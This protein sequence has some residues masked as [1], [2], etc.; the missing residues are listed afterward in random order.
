MA[1]LGAGQVHPQHE[2][3]VRKA[4]G[5]RTADRHNDGIAIIRRGNPQQGN[6]R[7]TNY[8]AKGDGRHPGNHPEVGALAKGAQISP[9]D[10]GRLD[11]TDPGQLQHH[12]FYWRFEKFHGVIELLINNVKTMTK[13][14]H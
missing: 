1:V 10:N 13:L 2:H 3:Q 8:I 11:K 5:H 7:P 9:I 12:L 4:V 6:Q 14:N